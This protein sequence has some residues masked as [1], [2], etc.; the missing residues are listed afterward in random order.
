VD[1]ETV[2]RYQS[3]LLLDLVKSLFD[4]VEPSLDVVPRR[5]GL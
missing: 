4:G 2:T 1:A 3:Q 5:K